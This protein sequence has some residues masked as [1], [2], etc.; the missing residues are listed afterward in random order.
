M[1]GYETSKLLHVT[2]DYCIGYGVDFGCELDPHP[3]ARTLVDGQPIV[4][5]TYQATHEVHIRNINELFQDWP[6]NKFDF[7]YS[8]HVIEHLIDPYAFLAECARLTKPGGHIVVVGP[9]ED[10]Y[11]PNGHPYANPDHKWWHLNQHKIAKWLRA[12][13]LLRVVHSSEHGR[14]EDNWSFIVVAE[15]L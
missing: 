15:K 2:S 5:S 9:H 6:D 13:P 11:W 12:I 8:S 3:N 7:T 4:H 10:W 1:P 14:D